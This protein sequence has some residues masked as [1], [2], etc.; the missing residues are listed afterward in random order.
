MIADHNHGLYGGQHTS[1]QIPPNLRPL[2]RDRHVLIGKN[3]W[4]GNGV[5]VCAGA[6]IGE[7]SVVGA[8]SVVIGD[9]PPFTIAAGVPAKVLKKYDLETS[10]W[11]PAR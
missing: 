6:E 3:V 11:I 1:P 5:V 7:G 4:L 2:D 9:I 8:N 10:Q